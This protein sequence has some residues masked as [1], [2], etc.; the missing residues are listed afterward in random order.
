MI[1][2]LDKKVCIFT[3]PRPRY[4]DFSIC[5]ETP[6]WLNLSLWS[7]KLFLLFW[8]EQTSLITPI[9]STEVFE[10]QSFGIRN[11][12]SQDGVLFILRCFPARFRDSNAFWAHFRQPTRVPSFSILTLHIST[13][14]QPLSQVLIANQQPLWRTK[15]GVTKLCGMVLRS[16]LARLVHWK[17]L[18]TQKS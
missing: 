3:W 4:I 14:C 2:R 12:H 16:V 5:G 6:V 15:F 9:Q 1:N 10:P 11:F 7:T 17:L 13:L 8:K 18:W